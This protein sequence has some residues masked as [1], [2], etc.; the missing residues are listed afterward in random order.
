MPDDASTKIL[1]PLIA[2]VARSSSSRLFGT[3]QSC[4]AGQEKQDQRQISR[5]DEAILHEEDYGKSLYSTN[6]LLLEIRSLHPDWPTIR[7]C[8]DELRTR[9]LLSARNL[10]LYCVSLLLFL[11]FCWFYFRTHF[12]GFDIKI[13]AW[14]KSIRHSL[15]THTHIYTKMAGEGLYG[16]SDKMA[17][18]E[19]LNS[20]V[21]RNSN[22]ATY[23]LKRPGTFIFTVVSKSRF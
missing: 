12:E 7:P 6:N 10:C 2:S 21:N 18:I 16:F 19:R 14:K 1:G 11:Y 23:G 13:E 20:Y 9:L 3:A 22:V 5:K 17:F 15:C 8:H 4:K